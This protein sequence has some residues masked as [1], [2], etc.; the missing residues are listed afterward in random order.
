MLKLWANLDNPK[1]SIFAWFPAILC[2]LGSSYLEPQ[3]LTL[4]SPSPLRENA[5][6]SNL[7]LN[8]FVCVGVFCLNLGRWKFTCCHFSYN[9]FLNFLKALRVGLY[10]ERVGERRLI[11]NG[12]SYNFH[13][14]L[15]DSNNAFLNNK[16]LVELDIHIGYMLQFPG[17]F[18]L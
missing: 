15:S 1:A 11:N 10:M 18:K 4:F 13:L 8:F 5:Y 17:I 2:I 6:G 16:L 9:Y 3:P 14:Y 12:G 7:F